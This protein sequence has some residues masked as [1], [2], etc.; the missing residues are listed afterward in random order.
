MSICLPHTILS[1]MV[2]SFS[3][4]IVL[5]AS[6]VFANISPHS[7]T[8]INILHFPLYDVIYSNHKTGIGFFFGNDRAPISDL[9]SSVLKVP[10]TWAKPPPDGKVIGTL[11]AQ[12]LATCS[13]GGNFGVHPFMKMPFHR[14]VPWFFGLGIQIGWKLGWGLGV[15][16]VEG[17]SQGWVLVRGHHIIGNQVNRCK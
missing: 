16:M 9:T 7:P 11:S 1:A 6:T 2:F 5:F 10:T 3:T 12:T 17:N 8:I 13:V 14:P 15:S 4:N